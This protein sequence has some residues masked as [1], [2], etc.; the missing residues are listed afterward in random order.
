MVLKR[1]HSIENSNISGSLIYLE[2]I[3]HHYH[4]FF[5]NQCTITH[6]FLYK[7]QTFCFQPGCFLTFCQF[8][9][10]MF[11]KCFL[12]FLKL[13]ITTKTDDNLVQPEGLP[14]YHVPPVSTL[15]PTSNTPDNQKLDD[16]L[17]LNKQFLITTVFSSLLSKLRLP[18]FL[19]CFLNFG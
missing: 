14:N 19:K 15:D 8:Q 6:F 17:L 16:G 18:M 10:Q 5:Y 4:L 2:A 13:L 12:Q 9:P 7:K 3:L 1:Y 11:L